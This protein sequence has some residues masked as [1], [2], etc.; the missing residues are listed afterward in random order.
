MTIAFT[1][2]A[3]S[4]SLVADA[5]TNV[6]KYFVLNVAPSIGEG[7]PSVGALTGGAASGS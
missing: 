5:T 3:V 1:A 7:I 6:P 4:F 2:A